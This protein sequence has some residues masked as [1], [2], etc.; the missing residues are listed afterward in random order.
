MRILEITLIDRE[1]YEPSRS[2]RI[3]VNFDDLSTMTD[4]TK[5]HLVNKVLEKLEEEIA[6][7]GNKTPYINVD[8]IPDHFNGG[9]DPIK[10]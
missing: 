10:P 8:F 4:Q 2:A 3:R 1:G 5:L 6:T 9:C 7:I